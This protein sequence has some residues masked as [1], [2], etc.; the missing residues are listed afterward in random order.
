MSKRTIF[1]HA[2]CLFKSKVLREAGQYDIIARSFRNRPIG[3]WFV[4]FCLRVERGWSG[5]GLRTQTRLHAGENISK[6]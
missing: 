3:L 6:G 5:E 4:A 1:T 2:S